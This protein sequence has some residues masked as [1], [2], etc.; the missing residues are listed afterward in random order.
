M[1]KDKV[2]KERGG[3]ERKGKERKGKERKGKE[4]KGKGRFKKGQMYYMSHHCGDSPSEPISTKFGK[5]M[6]VPDLVT[7]A[8]FGIGRSKG[9]V[10]RVVQ[11]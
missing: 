9:L 6:Q 7:P 5:S 1:H 11:K 4:R 8:N 10:Y 3:K 2:G